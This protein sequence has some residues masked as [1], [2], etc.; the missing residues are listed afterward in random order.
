MELQKY[1]VDALVSEITTGK[2]KRGSKNWT[3]S[4]AKL[5][6]FLKR[7][8]SGQQAASVGDFRFDDQGPKGFADALLQ[9]ADTANE[10]GAKAQA[11]ALHFS[12]CMQKM[13]RR[14]HER[15]HCAFCLEELWFAAAD[16]DSKDGKNA[17]AMSR[18]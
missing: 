4:N 1:E 17:D 11:R 9:F 10:I 8:V 13:P 7:P 15:I 2:L 16:V 5:Q 14:S 12:P 6:A 3:V 18:C